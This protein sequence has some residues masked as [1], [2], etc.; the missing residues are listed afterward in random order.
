MTLLVEADQKRKHA[1]A[2][3]KLVRSQAD[4]WYLPLHGIQGKTDDADGLERIGMQEVFDFLGVPAKRREARLHTRI[5]GIMAC[6][7]WSPVFDRSKDK[8]NTIVRS[9]ERKPTKTPDPVPAAAIAPEHVADVVIEDTITLNGKAE[10]LNRGVGQLFVT[11]CARVAEGVTDA[12]AIQFKY[13]LDEIAWHELM[14][15]TKLDRYVRREN[16]RRLRNGAAA[17]EL[18]QRAMPEA[19]KALREIVADRNLS[20]GYRVGAVKELR[21]TASGAREQPGLGEKFSIHI[22]FAS[23]TVELNVQNPQ[24]KTDGGHVL[25]YDAREPQDAQIPEEVYPDE[26]AAA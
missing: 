18:A 25:E 1:D 12:A 2:A 9:F 22:S 26:E 17:R 15:N 14:S 24:P 4:A 19:Q 5:I 6:F 21:E 23:H 8:K 7:S 13:E 11:D 3:A 16:E 10:P 20:A